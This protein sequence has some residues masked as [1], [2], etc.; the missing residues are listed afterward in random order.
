M[1]LAVGFITY[2]DNSAKYLPEFLASLQAS[3]E[4]LTKID[5]QVYAY[6][7]SVDNSRNRDIIENFNS[8]GFNIELIYQN[9]NLGFG[10]AY[11]ILI[12]Q[13]AV[14]QCDYFLIVNPDTLL[15]ERAVFELVLALENDGELA[16]VA[17]KLL[18]WDFANRKKTEIIDSLG[19]ILSPG[20]KFTDLGQGGIDRREKNK[21]AILG[22]SGAAGYF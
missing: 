13:A 17:P 7:N 21:A 3:L 1:K 18:R 12:R 9:K 5:Y 19:L 14:R 6:D 22:P 16:S 11:N 8:P 2:N 10:K 15:D 4:Y 20:L